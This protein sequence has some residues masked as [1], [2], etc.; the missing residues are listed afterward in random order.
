[1]PFE[2]NVFINCPFDVEYVVLLRPLLFTIV[3][4]RLEPRIV[5]TTDSGQQRVRAIEQLIQES[6][7]SIHDLFRITPLQPGEWPRLNMSYELGLDMG[8]RR[9]GSP[10]L[11]EKRCL[12]LEKEPHR[13]QKVLSDIAGSDIE[14]HQEGPQTLIRKVRNWFFGQNFGKLPSP[15]RIWMDFNEFGATL[16]SIVQNGNYAEADFTEMPKSE[17]VLYAKEWINGRNK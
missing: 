2:R 8:C 9:F 4:L 16:T 1:M 14:A 7:Y 12:I 6:K 15:N 10:P 3:Y 13:Y 17:F 5:E 11:T